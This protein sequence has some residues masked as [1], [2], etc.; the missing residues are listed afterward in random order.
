MYYKFDIPDP[1]AAF[2][3]EYKIK[4]KI[5]ECCRRLIVKMRLP[6]KKTCKWW[7]KFEL[8]DPEWPRT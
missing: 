8:N 3:T 4:K 6:K 2:I 5:N 1:V 7:K